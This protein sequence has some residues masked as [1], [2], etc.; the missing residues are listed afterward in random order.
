MFCL[1]MYRDTTYMP[2]RSEE[3]QRVVSLFMGTGNR[4]Q[5]L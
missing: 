1:H 3:L 5:V 4:T 2:Q